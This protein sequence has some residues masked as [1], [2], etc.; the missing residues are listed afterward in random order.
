MFLENPTATYN[1]EVFE[2]YLKENDLR[3]T[4]SRKSFLNLVCNLTQP[5]TIDDA[6]NES[7]ESED[8][9]RSTVYCNIPILLK[10]KII[11]R[12]I[13]ETNEVKVIEKFELIN[14]D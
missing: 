12:I 2:D 1:T 6:I 5:F 8:V 10:S 7:Y 11:R 14:N 13:I 3:L 4:Q 9:S